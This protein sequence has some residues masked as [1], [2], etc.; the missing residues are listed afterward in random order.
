MYIH[1]NSCIFSLDINIT[2]HGVRV[3]VVLGLSCLISFFKNGFM[4]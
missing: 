1:V 3:V 2:E 4:A